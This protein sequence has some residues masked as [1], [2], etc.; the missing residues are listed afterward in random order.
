MIKQVSV[1]K[2]LWQVIR[3]KLIC[4]ILITIDI[5]WNEKRPKEGIV[6]YLVEFSK[7][8]KWF[9]YL[10]YLYTHINVFKSQEDFCW[11]EITHQQKTAQKYCWAYFV[12]QPQTG[13]QHNSCCCC[14]FSIPLISVVELML[15]LKL[16]LYFLSL[17]LSL[18]YVLHSVNF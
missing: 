8:W 13:L 3:I 18:F 16:F 7:K 17:H 10:L 12:H 9:I 15:Y 6:E 4:W 11:I 2:R 14:L 5:K 1:S